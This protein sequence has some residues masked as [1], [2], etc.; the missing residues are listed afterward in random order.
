MRLLRWIQLHHRRLLRLLVIGAV[1][2]LVCWV[3]ITAYNYFTAS[4]ARIKTELVAGDACFAKGDST[5]A[6]LHYSAAV[7][8][9]DKLWIHD[10][11]MAEA[12]EKCVKSRFIWWF[13]ST[14]G[15]LGAS[16]DYPPDGFS[17]DK[18]VHNAF[19]HISF[20]NFR[21]GYLNYRKACRI[22]REVKEVW[23]SLQ[24]AYAIRERVQGKYHPDLVK[25]LEEQTQLATMT[26]DDTRML[27]ILQ[28][29]LAISEKADGTDNTL[30]AKALH[31]LA[32][33]YDD[34]IS[35]DNR[36]SRDS[37]K[38]LDYALRAYAILLRHP[39][40]DGI[41]LMDTSMMLYL[42][43]IHNNAPV[44]CLRIF[45]QTISTIEQY[46]GHNSRSNAMAYNLLGQCYRQLHKI[47][48]AK[49]AFYRELNTTEHLHN[50][51]TS[52]RAFYRKLMFSK[53][54][55]HI[56]RTS[57]RDNALISLLEKQ[58]QFTEEE[59]VLLYVLRLREQIQGSP[60]R[61]MY[62]ILK[63]LI[64]FYRDQKRYR[65][66]EKYAQWY[67]TIKSQDN[68]TTASLTISELQKIG[69]IMTECGNVALTKRCFQYAIKLAA[70]TPTIRGYRYA[71]LLASYSSSL[72]RF[73]LRYEAHQ[74]RIRAKKLAPF[75]SDG[76]FT[77]DYSKEMW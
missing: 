66:V 49:A 69:A 15:K 39:D 48:E 23:H 28:Q 76:D 17:P 13:D 71:T 72:N 59:H 65:D 33:W 7:R 42:K 60:S 62:D 6:L 2:W 18:E 68:I 8:E 44:E 52:L 1:V 27:P 29:I 54:Y 45:K 10:L 25:V 36:D 47:P 41:I 26:K 63:K 75:L 64:T 35:D 51:R 34:Y 9:G 56:A 70:R 46:V 3:P 55:D 19:T 74:M 21:D 30:T 11:R 32:I 38:A 67:L 40:P 14:H 20:D 73:G 37:K 53:Y 58:K 24:R 5:T 4:P 57:I 61:P 43:Y 12:L 31:K 77:K 16:N 22:R 50:D